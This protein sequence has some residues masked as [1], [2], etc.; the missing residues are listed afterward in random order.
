MIISEHSSSYQKNPRKCPNAH[1][2]QPSGFILFNTYLK[3]YFSKKNLTRTTLEFQLMVM[4]AKLTY[5]TRKDVQLCRVTEKKVSAT[6][7]SV[8]V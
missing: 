6:L 1:M 8:L 3:V 4:L 5:D 2:L 7:S